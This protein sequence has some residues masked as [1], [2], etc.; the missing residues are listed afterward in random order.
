MYREMGVQQLYVK[1]CQSGPTSTGMGRD[2]SPQ[3]SKLYPIDHV[4][5]FKINHGYGTI[6]PANLDQ[7]RV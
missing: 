1:G 5:D 4:F 3:K 2:C 7:M 6:Y